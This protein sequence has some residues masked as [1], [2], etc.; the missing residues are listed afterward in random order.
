MLLDDNQATALDVNEGG[1]SYQKFVT[2]NGGEK[3]VFG[4]L[5]EAPVNSVIADFTISNGSIVSATGTIDFDN[6]NLVSTGTADFGATTVDSLDVSDGNITN[7]G[8]I[9]LDTISSDGSTVQILMDDNVAGSFEIKEGLNSYLKVDTTDGSEL[10]TVSK[11]ISVTGTSTFT[12]AVS[13][14]QAVTVNDSGSAVDFRVEGDNQTH[15]IYT[16]GTNDRVGINNNAP[17]VQLDVTGDTLITGAT[18]VSGTTSLDGAVVVNESGA[19]VDFRVEGDNEVNLIFADASADSVG[20]GNNAPSKTLDITGTL[21]LSSDATFAGVANFTTASQSAIT[22]NSDLG[23]G[24]AP[25]VNDDFGLTVNRGSSTDAKLYW[26]EGNDVWQFETGNLQVQNSIVADSDA[27]GAITISDGTITSASGAISFDNENLSTTGTLGVGVATVTSLNVTDDGLTAIVLNSDLGAIAPSQNVGITVERGTSTDAT[28]FYDETANT[29]K[30][31]RGEGVGAETVLTENDTIFTLQTDGSGGGSAFTFEQTDGSTLLF[32]DAGNGQMVITNANGTVNLS[33]EDSFDVVTDL[34]VGRNLTV[35]GNIIG[36][37]A[38]VS[39]N[40]PIV[41]I[42]DGNSSQ[43]NDLGFYGEYVN[44]GA[45]SRYAGLLYQPDSVSDNGVWKLFDLHSDAIGSLD[46]NVTV[47]DGELST[48][49]ID[50]LNAKGGNVV[51]TK[52]ATTTNEDTASGN[53]TSNNG[54]ISVTVTLNGN[55][56]DDTRRGPI[57]VTSDK[58]LSTSVVLGNASVQADTHIHSVVAGSFKFD[59]TNRS[60]ADLVDDSTIVFNFVIM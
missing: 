12:G 22:F 1:T 34:G 11:E 14:D 29:W 58:V 16:D 36:N 10:I 30:V 15:L 26:D 13:L 8:D 19:D 2:T 44:S 60:G 53:F 9:A 4:K 25:D 31:N 42:A 57:T 33:L 46:T 23:G 54:A 32:Q 49:D 5:I 17:T 43:V 37:G 41:Q 56:A 21:G 18:T 55:L 3:V 28:V 6:E 20:I 48:L 52:T 45:N 40:D 27:G 50:T 59:Y 51:I 24:D 38:R 47:T 35:T 7:V 39:F